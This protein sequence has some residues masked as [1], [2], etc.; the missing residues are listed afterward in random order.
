M[1]NI[2]DMFRSSGY[3]YSPDYDDGDPCYSEPEEDNR[4]Q[5]RRSSNRS[6]EVC[7]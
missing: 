1:P 2:C 4:N 6:Y 7:V 3:E 5:Y